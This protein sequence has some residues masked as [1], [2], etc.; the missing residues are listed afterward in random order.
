MMRGTRRELMIYLSTYLLGKKSAQLN[1]KFIS[2]Y[3]GFNE[4]NKPG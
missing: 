4:Q 3:F 1:A 2:T